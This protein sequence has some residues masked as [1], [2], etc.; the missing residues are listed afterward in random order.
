MEGDTE[1]AKAV[2]PDAGE[3]VLWTQI[4]MGQEAERARLAREI[5]DGP[6]QVLANTVMRFQLVEQMQK[7]Q[8]KEVEGELAKVRTA[9][10]E[11]LKDI[12]R[13]IFNLRPASLSDAGLLPT[14]RQYVQEST[15]Q[16]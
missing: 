12:R 2:Q 5:H 9:L 10:Q 13:F 4:I 7:H 6:A 3:Q 14:L 1:A 16:I 11:S 8:P 15:E